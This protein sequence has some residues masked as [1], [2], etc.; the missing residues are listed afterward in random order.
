MLPLCHRFRL[1][2]H[3]SMVNLL[4][5]A[6]KQQR[7]RGS[8]QLSQARDSSQGSGLFQLFAKEVDDSLTWD[9]IPWLRTITKLPIYVKV[10]D[11]AGGDCRAGAAPALAQTR[12][13]CRVLYLTCTEVPGW[14]F[15]RQAGA[16]AAVCRCAAEQPGVSC[17]RVCWPLRTP[18]WLS[19]TA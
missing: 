5:L 1:P 17:C 12:L 15:V 11:G 10:K 7:Q 13:R 18:W 16:T 14:A 3:L 4:P 2:D 9:F 19:S 8:G 6:E